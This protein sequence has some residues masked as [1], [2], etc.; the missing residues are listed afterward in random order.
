MIVSERRMSDDLFVPVEKLSRDQI[1]DLHRLFQGEWWTKGRTLRQTRRLVAQSDLVVAIC[2][3]PSAGLAAF[4][5]VLTDFAVRALI[6][7]V[8]VAPQFRS[9]GLG[10]QLMEMVLAHP[11]LTDVSSISLHC[12][13]EMI[14]FYEQWGFRMPEDVVHMVLRRGR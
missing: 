4:A 12:H 8:I 1:H 6:C 7:D 13:R 11:K 10:R 5:R 2:H 14:P 3:L 9:L